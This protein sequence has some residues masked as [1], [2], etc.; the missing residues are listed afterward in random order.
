[1]KPPLSGGPRLA[2][3]TPHGNCAV[4][5]QAGEACS[6]E[7]MFITNQTEFKTTVSALRRELKNAFPEVPSHAA[8]QE[9]LAK[10]LGASSYAELLTK[11][12]KEP[13]KRKA[14]VSKEA[15]ARYPLQNF[16][17][18]F[19]LVKQGEQGTPVLGY[20]FEPVQ[21]TQETIPACV[22]YASL[23]TR[24]D[25]GKFK[26]EHDGE[27]EINWD[28][29][30]TDLDANGFTLWMDEDGNTV[31][32]GLIVLVP[33][34]FA[35]HDQDLPVRRALVKEY[36]RYVRENKLMDALG[37][38]LLKDGYECETLQQVAETLGFALTERELVWLQDSL[39]T[40][41][42]LPDGLAQ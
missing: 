1:M 21:G 31:S 20:S 33:E 42:G 19:D 8:M 25:N 11:L 41:D 35:T 14:E 23:A 15:P 27:T 34:D 22:S 36:D 10:A 29:Q 30:K 32:S 37:A 24:K 39:K 38:D 13:A 9:L 16:D 40:A 17:G 7:I 18:R 6:K 3:R 4:V 28:G 12:P 26:V 5:Y 2:T